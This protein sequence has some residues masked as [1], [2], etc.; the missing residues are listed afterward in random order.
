MILL[1]TN[2]LTRLTRSGRESTAAHA[3][4]P[5]PLC[6]TST[7]GASIASMVAVTASTWS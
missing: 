7:T 5:P 6:P 2:L 1:D 4:A 3:I